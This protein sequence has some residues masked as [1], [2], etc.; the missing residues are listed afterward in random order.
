MEVPDLTEETPGGSWGVQLWLGLLR[1]RKTER[2]KGQG[3]LWSERGGGARVGGVGL[4]WALALSYDPKG[5]DPDPSTDR[6]VGRRNVVP[7][8]AID[9][10]RPLWFR[11][12][13]LVQPAPPR[14][15]PI[16]CGSSRLG[17]GMGAI[18]SGPPSRDPGAW[19]LRSSGF[20]Q[21]Y[22]SIPYLLDPTEPPRVSVSSQE[23]SYPGVEA[24]SRQW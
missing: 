2:R 12:C 1:G 21:R 14:P 23:I 18:G 16:P 15:V 4:R 20:G 6:V 17:E 5:R 9:V 3:Y 22:G 10:V 11:L 7:V 19:R 24:V 13:A 8:P